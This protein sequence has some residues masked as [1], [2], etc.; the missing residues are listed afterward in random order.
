MAK[1]S[2]R[3]YNQEVER[4]VDGGQLD[5]AIAHCRHILNAFPK[6]LETYRLLGK[7]YLESK[8]YGEATD[9]FER[10]LMAVPDD[11]VSHVGMSIINDEQKNMDAAIWHMER[12]FEVQP[13]N[14]AIQSEL[15]RLYGR[16]DGVEPPKIRLTRGALAHMYVQGELYTQA[17]SEIKNVLEDDAGRQDMQVLLARAYFNAGQ[18]NE[19]AE[20]C[21]QL[22]RRYPYCFDAN[23]VLA[24]LLPQSER[25]ESTQIYRQRISELDPYSLFA[26]G[27]L[28]HTDEVPDAAVN[29]ERLD[30]DGQTVDT[31]PEW[32]NSQGIE[33]SDGFVTP[34]NQQPDWLKSGL[35]DNASSASF[36]TDEPAA[37]SGGLPVPV[38]SGSTEEELP[39]F[40]REAGWGESTGAFQEGSIDFDDTEDDISVEPL[41]AGDMPDWIKAMAPDGV[42]N[43]P[44]PTTTQVDDVDDLMQDD[45]PDWLQ[46]IGDSHDETSPEQPTAAESTSDMPDW[47]G[48]IQSLDE[49][50]ADRQIQLDETPDVDDGLPDWLEEMK[51]KEG[52]FPAP[53]PQAQA[54]EF[55]DGGSDLP[56]WLDDMKSTGDDGLPDWLDDMRSVDAPVIGSD[57]QAV[58][59]SEGN[60]GVPD[61]LDEMKSVDVPQSEPQTLEEDAIIGGEDIPDWLYDTKDE[62]PPI[63]K[64]VSQQEEESLTVSSETLADWQIEDDEVSGVEPLGSSVEEQ[65]DAMAWLEGLAAKHG[66]KAEELVTDPSARKET[67]PEWVQHEQAS[68][69]SVESIAPQEKL[70]VDEEPVQ[71]IDSEPALSVSAD[72]SGITP[73]EQDDAM[74]WLEGLASKHG[75]KAEEL[76]TDPSTRKESAP[77]WVQQTETAQEPV[78]TVAPQATQ[79]IN[80]EPA[81]PV[82]SKLA[83]PVGADILG[84]SPEEQDEAVAWLESLA[85]KHGAKDEE[86]VTDPSA[87][88]ETA[89]DWVQQTS[90]SSI[91]QSGAEESTTV[92]ESVQDAEEED[93]MKRAKEV[94]ETLFAELEESQTKDPIPVADVDE[95][96]MW[97]QDLDKESKPEA[98]IESEPDGDVS[99]W[100]AD[101]DDEEPGPESAIEA[102]AS[103]EPVSES[104]PESSDWVHIM[105][106][107]SAAAES[108]EESIKEAPD[109]GGELPSWLEGMESELQE[110]KPGD[111]GDLPD[112]LSSDD[113]PGPAA[114]V[115][116]VSPSDWKP[117]DSVETSPQTVKTFVPAEE[118]TSAPILE[119]SSAPDQEPELKTK[120]EPQSAV[121]SERPADNETVT[122][123]RSSMT[124]IL[125]PAQDP[126]LVQAQSDLG[127]SNIPAAMESYAKLIKK[128]KMLDE[129]IFDLREA[130]YRFPVEVSIL[131]TLGDAYMRANRLQDALDAYT[132]AEELLR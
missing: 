66:A 21:S 43:T 121:D 15:Q 58:G 68:Q 110:D 77:D 87:R 111:E 63:A 31:Q 54:V 42:E 83:M 48:D 7:A 86:L 45:I 56:N 22:L 30:W 115:E 20:M 96:G 35:T 124:S 70:P 129:V 73:E 89:P 44:I 36:P 5:E 29:L 104:K 74:A 125:S 23:R 131:Q 118:S 38:A 119:T 103:L 128:G 4:L 94:G 79:P 2:L 14:A 71:P 100:L 13:S 26:T 57:S 18:Q 78:E 65:D 40:L 105:E 72:M 81:L 1:V 117:A 98:I 17:I 19:S 108:D 61:W 122:P 16:R 99:D 46:G 91:E 33:K 11:F 27:S 51:P 132:K 80:E 107:G 113:E 67:A 24:E 8:R 120:L 34:D 59:E 28:F 64:E 52:P 90:L 82:E 25:G 75:A 92:E 85:A 37:I 62:V 106:D 93:W 3:I 123:G 126:L 114:P 84:T 127:R 112:W 39:N 41:A 109:S 50:A 88:R 76:I 130:I 55:S 97:L 12:A 10:V 6:N 95:T 60:D 116:P 53:E 102:D 47:I 9:I 101:L 49:P 32:S 69:G